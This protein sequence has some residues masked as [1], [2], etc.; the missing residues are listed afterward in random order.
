MTG[1]DLTVARRVHIR[2]LE[3]AIRVRLDLL[4]VL[5]TI[6][7]AELA[8]KEGK[9]KAVLKSLRSARSAL[10]A[11]TRD[12]VHGRIDGGFDPDVVF[13]LGSHRLI[14]MWRPPAPPAW[15]HES[16][17]IAIVCTCLEE[18]TGDAQIRQHWETGCYDLPDFQSVAPVPEDEDWNSFLEGLD[19]ERDA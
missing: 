16:G 11:I 9:R 3:K 4:G 12:G 13:G 6:E 17:C 8:F 15:P 1:D 2:A 14:G 5:K 10:S 7:G 19:V 18:L